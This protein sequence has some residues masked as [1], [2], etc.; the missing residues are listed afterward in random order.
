LPN[1]NAVQN[2]V[3]DRLRV[4]QA[5]SYSVEREPH[6]VDEKEPDIR[7]RAKVSDASLP[8][9]IKVAESWTLAKLEI[10]L[11]DQLCGQYLRARD[12]KH[13]ILLLVHQKARGKGWR[14]KS[15]GAYLT[16]HQVVEHLSARATAIAASRLDAPQPE[17]A[18][19]DV[20]SCATQTRF[21]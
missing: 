17:I 13:G 18:V 1:E 2:W 14:R 7:L 5:R 10:A 19:L 8:I 4:A 15:G 11:D 16:F 9:E 12:G 20:S 6:V 21:P 3:A